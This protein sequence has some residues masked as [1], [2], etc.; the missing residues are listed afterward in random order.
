MFSR[1]SS[2]FD[3]GG[4]LSIYVENG[5][6]I[7]R[8]QSTNQ[9][10]VITSSVPVTAG[11]DHDVR[12]DFGSGGMELYLDGN[13]VGSNNYTG[14]ITGNDEP[15]VLGA[16][17]IRS[18]NAEADR[19][20]DHLSGTISNFT[21]GD[22]TGNETGRLDYLGGFG[23]SEDQIVT[24]QTFDLPVGTSRAEIN[25]DFLEIDTWN[26]ESL[27]LEINGDVFALGT[28]HWQDDEAS[29]A[30]YLAP[31]IFVQKT[32]AED[33]SGLGGSAGSD[34]NNDNRHNFTITI[35]NPSRNLTIGFGSDLSAPANN[36]SWGI[37][38]FKLR[39]IG[40]ELIL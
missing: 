35:E 6:L 13:L 29:Q 39:A 2:G 9:S 24:R 33:V 40:D 28:F 17:Q 7:V 22:G 4:H 10:H 30:Y 26:N 25:F 34:F 36:E 18:G 15:I 27:L 32:A 20:E 19:L 12:F 21:I 11:T 14:G 31:G 1:D 16:L 37:D 3:G 5:D 38:N 8:L 23:D